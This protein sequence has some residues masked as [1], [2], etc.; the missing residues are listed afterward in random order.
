[1]S[2]VYLIDLYKFINQRLADAERLTDN[3]END[4]GALKF[5]EGQIDIL[6]D[7]KEF[8]LDNLNPKLPKAIRRKLG[9]SINK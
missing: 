9:T 2:Y 3:S 8:L 1:M 6:S 4:Q 5:R 7:F